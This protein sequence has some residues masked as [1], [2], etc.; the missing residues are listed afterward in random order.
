[1]NIGPVF[2]FKDNELVCAYSITK[3]D[4]F[5]A[6][7]NS[8]IKAI[9]RAMEFMKQASMPGSKYY[10]QLQLKEGQILIFAN[11]KI[12]HAAAKKIKQPE[13]VDGFKVEM[14]SNGVW[15]KIPSFFPNRRA[16]MKALR[17]KQV[18]IPRHP[19]A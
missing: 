13:H 11:S 5:V 16:K 17:S 1:M 19:I 3:T 7:Y 4:S 8:D 12:S 9:E 6:S 15:I 14:V 2:A 10:Y 18:T